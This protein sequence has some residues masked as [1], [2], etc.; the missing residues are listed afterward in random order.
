MPATS[1]QVGLVLVALI[2]EPAV[3]VTD[4]AGQCLQVVVQG[5]VLPRVGTAGQVVTQS[6]D[7]GSQVSA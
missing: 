7:E 1:R 4:P 2:G 3:E 6:E 5:G